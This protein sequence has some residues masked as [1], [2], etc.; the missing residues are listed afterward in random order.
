MQSVLTHFEE[1]VENEN[2]TFYETYKAPIRNADGKSVVHLAFHKTL[3]IKRTADELIKA[4]ELAEANS[5]AK[6]MFLANMS[7]EIR[8]PLNGLMGFLH[9]LENTTLT[10]QQAEFVN[11]IKISS[12]L[13]K[14]LTDDILDLSKIYIKGITIENTPFDL[15]NAIEDAVIP[16]T[17]DLYNKKIDINL[18]IHP[19]V[20]QFVSGDPIKLRQAISNIFNNAVKFTEKGSILVEA[21]LN[22]S[23]EHKYE[24]SIKIKDTGIEFLKM[25]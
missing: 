7:H 6:S 1:V 17:A 14:K 3:Q 9:L 24:I 21:L 19:N 4:K 12:K 20:P 18:F 8:T 22:N 2:G 5:E 13:L 23:N 10:Q 16:F 15:H 11:N 25:Q